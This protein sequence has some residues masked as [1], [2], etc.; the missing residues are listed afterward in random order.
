MPPP[1]RPPPPHQKG[2]DGLDSSWEQVEQDADGDAAEDEPAR[3]SWLRDATAIVTVRVKPIRQ[4]WNNNRT[5]LPGSV[6]IPNFKTPTP[7]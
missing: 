1:P 2:G 5:E 4:P 6:N 3:R 7:T